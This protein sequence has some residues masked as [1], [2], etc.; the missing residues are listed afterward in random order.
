M[1]DPQPS[2][3]LA[4]PLTARHRRAGV[5]LVP[6]DGALLPRAFGDAAAEVDALTSRAGLC[7][8]AWLSHFRATGRHRQRFLHNMSTCQIKALTPG[9]GRFGLLVEGKGRV[10]AQFH[11]DAEEDG[12]LLET[13]GERVEPAIA[14]LL[15]Y[16]VADDVHFTPEPGRRVLALIGP[17][18]AA[19]APGLGV[20]EL[21]AAD[22][23]W[24]EVSVGGIDARIRRNPTRLGL[25]GFDL[26]T[27]AGRG[28]DAVAL[29]EHLTAA[30][31]T[32]VG[33]DA[34]E[35]ARILAGWPREGV[36]IGIDNLPLEA[37][38]LYATIDWDKG[39]YIGQE[40]LAMT[41]YRGRPNKHLRRLALSSGAELPPGT[42]LT[43]GYKEVGRLGSAAV[44]P[45]SGER[46][47]LAVI[48][49]KHAE[50]GT[51]LTL[52]GGEA[53]VVEG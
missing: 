1:S 21:P 18:A 33:A 52:P 51:T 41:H 31:A 38:R 12:L 5:P 43:S 20:A 28:G 46:W 8:L 19:M 42:P 16:R 6:H 13:G 29:W 36:D 9:D 10:V 2:D 39:C 53:Q 45:R 24:R 27:R 49:R 30:G 32:P 25:G 44:D 14:Q 48:K 11:V 15:R 40:V 22:Y 26:T 50:P 23:A 7:D 3:P 47:A 35:V 37:E 17:A 4:A 34:M